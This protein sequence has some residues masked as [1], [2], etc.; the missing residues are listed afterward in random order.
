MHLCNVSHNHLC[1]LTWFKNPVSETSSIFGLFCS[2]RFLKYYATLIKKRSKHCFSDTWAVLTWSLLRGNSHL[3]QTFSFINNKTVWNST[4]LVFFCIR[5][6]SY[7]DLFIWI[8]S[9]HAYNTNVFTINAIV[10]EQT[11]IDL[12]WRFG[13]LV[14]Y[15][16]FHAFKHMTDI[17]HTD[18]HVNKRIWIFSNNLLEA[19]FHS[20]LVSEWVDKAEVGI[21]EARGILQLWIMTHMLI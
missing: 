14:Q 3:L 2:E 6:N 20:L 1:D 21:K 5:D 9:I 12:W 8:K 18:S 16:K 10:F 11:L 17:S 7:K 15:F 19:M 13:Y 4:K